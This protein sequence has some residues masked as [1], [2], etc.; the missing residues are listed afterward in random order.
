MKNK[1]LNKTILGGLVLLFLSG[2]VLASVIIR[3]NNYNVEEQNNDESEGIICT[4]DAKLCPDGSYVGR[5]GPNCEFVCPVT[6][7]NSTSTKKLQIKLNQSSKAIYSTITPVEVVEDS[8]CPVDVQCIQAGTVRLKLMVDSPS[9]KSTSIIKIG[10][11]LTTETEKI[12]FLGVAPTKISTT[13]IN[14]DNYTFEFKV[15]I[16]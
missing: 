4:M 3:E 7:P 16:K 14:L 5:T 12:T 1:Y 11:S 13:N 9:G 2:I 10:E 8:R 6:D 15:E